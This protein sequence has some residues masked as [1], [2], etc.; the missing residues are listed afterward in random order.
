MKDWHY[1][2]EYLTPEQWIEEH[3]QAAGFHFGALDFLR[4]FPASNYIRD[5]YGDEAWHEHWFWIHLNTAD[6]AVKQGKLLEEKLQ[7][8]ADGKIST[9]R[10]AEELGVNFF[11]LHSALMIGVKDER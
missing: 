2:G 6:D 5:K 4:T 8:Y 9:E 3:Y 10:L 1:K 7:D 11:V